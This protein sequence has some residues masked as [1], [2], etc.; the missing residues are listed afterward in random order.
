VEELGLPYAVAINAFDDAPRYPESELRE[1]L[2]L[3]PETPLVICDA[4]DR[5]SS[6]HALIA[7]VEHLLRRPVQEYV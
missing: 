7:L 6:T 5:V 3:L 2:D 4:R 1:A